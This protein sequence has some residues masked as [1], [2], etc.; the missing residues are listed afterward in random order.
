MWTSKAW[1]SALP[2]AAFAVVWQFLHECRGF[3]SYAVTA[4]LF[5]VTLLTIC[6]PRVRAIRCKSVATNKQPQQSDAHPASP[7]KEEKDKDI[8][9][10]NNV[11]KVM[12]RF[13]CEAIHLVD[14]GEDCSTDASSINEKSQQHPFAPG[15]MVLLGKGV[16]AEHRH[17]P[18]IITNVAATHCTAAVLDETRR[19]GVGECWPNFADVE[20]ESEAYRLDSLVVVNGLNKGKSLRLNGCVG[21]IAKHPKEGHPTFIHKPSE[22]NL[23]QLTLC[24]R[25]KDP[26]AAGQKC[27]LLAPKFLIP[28]QEFSQKTVHG[29]GQSAILRAMGS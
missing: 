15:D 13:S 12:H 24:V 6:W 2:L 19:Y 3:L 28:L 18:A 4:G 25:F 29:L 20:L 8:D 23:A 16:P 10:D 17:R 9:D 7:R 11:P 21:T 22:P 26:E 27:V 5:W 14:D 1:L